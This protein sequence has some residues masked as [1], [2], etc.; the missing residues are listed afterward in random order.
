MQWLASVGGSHL[1]FPCFVPHSLMKT[2]CLC[3]PDNKSCSELCSPFLKQCR[4]TCDTEGSRRTAQK[5]P[6]ALL[7]PGRMQEHIKIYTIWKLI[8]KV[9]TRAEE[10][11]KNKGWESQSKNL[12][13][14]YAYR[15]MLASQ[16]SHGPFRR[17]I[18]ESSPHLRILL[19][20]HVLIHILFICFLFTNGLW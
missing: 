2:P 3:Y 8:I 4:Y 11:M 7:V 20:G 6:C 9:K 19:M 16:M 17:D 13:T 5:F 10:K 14:A 15:D 18:C 12:P 1:S